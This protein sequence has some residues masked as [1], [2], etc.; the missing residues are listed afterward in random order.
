M[1]FVL[2]AWC[3]IHTAWYFCL[4]RLS[5][6]QIRQLN[7]HKFLLWF[8]GET[9]QTIR[10]SHGPITVCSLSRCAW[11]HR[12]GSAVWMIPAVLCLEKCF[13]SPFLQVCVPW[14]FSSIFYVLVILCETRDEMIDGHAQHPLLWWPTSVGSGCYQTVIV[15]SEPGIQ[16]C[17]HYCE[18]I[19]RLSETGVFNKATG[20]TV[21]RHLT[22]FSAY[23][24]C[25]GSIWF[26]VGKERVLLLMNISVIHNVNHL[27]ETLIESVSNSVRVKH[28]KHVCTKYWHYL[29]MKHPQVIDHV[30]KHQKTSEVCRRAL[31]TLHWFHSVSVLVPQS[32]QHSR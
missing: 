26:S 31:H 4:L 29:N 2:T 8:D 32:P 18:V 1:F 21:T 28:L 23:N 14:N 11:C 30:Q 22:C 15:R 17:C 6:L 20:E 5:L 27:V 13:T 25:Y 10:W 24:R 12:E 19:K 7:S 16:I 9:W 3:R